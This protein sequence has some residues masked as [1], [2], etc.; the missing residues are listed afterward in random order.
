MNEKILIIDDEIEI[1]TFLYDA[2]E[3]EGYQV[4]KAANGEE[5]LRQL[6]HGPDLLILDVMMPG[7]SG[8]ELCEQIRKSVDV[9]ILFLSAKQTENDRVQGLLV[10]GDDYL[11]KP[12]SLRE[13]KMRVLA[14]LRREER[15]SRNQQKCLY[16][17]KIHI[18]LKSCQ[19]FYDAQEVSLTMREFEI[20]Q[21]LAMN[22]GQALTREQIYVKVW[23]LEATG[24]S[25]T[26][27]EHIKNIRAKLQKAGEQNSI[28][29]TVWG[30]G[31]RWEK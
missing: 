9:P 16:F 30:R 21:Y 23:G 8:F 12:F 25:I 5:A 1:L 31:Y 13:L 3:D 29:S 27:N 18:D 6:K 7:M 11:V 17:G 19:L 20:V 24:D 4:L 15:K 26:I 28:I 14:H 2:L 22:C 10:G